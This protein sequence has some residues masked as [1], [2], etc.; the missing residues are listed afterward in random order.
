MF[1]PKNNMQ[2]IQ[3]HDHLNKGGLVD[4]LSKHVHD[5]VVT[6]NQTIANTEALIKPHHILTAAE[7]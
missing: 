3:Q 5:S 6:T 7:I 2:F 1:K 4:V